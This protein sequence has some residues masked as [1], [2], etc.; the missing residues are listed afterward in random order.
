MIKNFFTSAFRNLWKTKGYSFLNIFGLAIGIAAA[1]L[2]FLWVENEVTR[3]DHFSNKKDIYVVKSQQKYDDAISVFEAT[4]GLLGPAIQAEIPGIKNVA[5][6]DWSNSFLFS[7]GDKNL[8]QRGYHADPAILDILSVEFLAGNRA[9]AL[10][11]LNNIVL[12]ERVAQNL[13]GKESAIGKTVRVNNKESYIVSGIVKEFPKNSSYRFD[14][15]I[16]FKKYEATNQWLNQWGSNSVMTLVQTETNA[17]ITKINAAMLEFVARKTDGQ[18]TFSKNFIYPMERWNL[19]NRFD[20]DGHEQEGFI[21]YVR[22]FSVIAWVVL[23]IACIN[24]MNLATARSEKRA[25]EVGMRKVVGASRQTLIFQFLSESLLYAFLSTLVAIGFVYLSISSF[26]SL[27][28]KE[29]NVNLFK[30]T[31]LFFMIGIIFSC[32]LLA[33]S[34]PAFYLSSLNP[35]KSIKG[36]KQKGKSAGFIRKG[37]VILQYSASVVLIICTI[38]IYQQI[39]HAKNRDMGYDRSQVIT[40]PLRGDMAE[41]LAV[42]KDELKATGHIEAVGI[43][44]MNVMEIYSN[45]GGFDWDGKDKNTNPLI[46]ILKTDEDLITSLGMKLYDGRN[47]R[48]KFVGD[49]SSIIINETFAK[50]IK[51][52]GKAAGQIIRFG[53]DSYIVA[54]VVHDFVYNNVYAASPEPVAFAPFNDVTGIVNIRT[55]AGTD[56]PKA[57][58][59]IEK[60]IKTNN[61]G[62]PFEYKFLDETFNTKFSSELMIQKLA[63]VFAVLSIIISCLGLFGLASYSAEQRSKEIGI[64]KVLGASVNQLIGMLNRDFIIL[65]GV[66]CLIAFPLAWWFMQDWLNSYHYKIEIGWIV[67]ALAALAA[68]AIATL[69]VSSQA[70]RA[71]LANPTKTLRDE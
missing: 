45:S 65:V 26:N 63:S 5:R 28:Y 71:A 15:L 21:K 58:A 47:F 59:Q 68:L 11:D 49:S 43:S 55:K 69:T 40:T 34:Y 64:R 61:P 33:G 8:Y 9:S 22:L 37:L 35:L 60:I 29:L 41:H 4:P 23:L 19:Y 31:H 1:S 10:T 39:Q 51:A 48:S 13:F 18:V 14:W 7:V 3:N 54:G 50:M 42:I 53:S 25:K 44:D 24:F 36:G 27:I 6:L 2:I 52:D 66:S 46:G 62:Y 56:L 30:S 57:I 12:N 32:G 16:N 70:L 20:K 38:I 67:F 17:D